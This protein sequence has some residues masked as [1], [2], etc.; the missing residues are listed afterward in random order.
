[1]AGKNIA[2]NK[3]VH[4]VCDKGSGCGDKPVNHNRP[5]VIC[6]SKNEPGNTCD[7]KSSNLGEHVETVP[8]IRSVHFYCL[9]NDATLRRVCLVT[10]P[11]ASSGH[12]LNGPAEDDHADSA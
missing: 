11:C 5:P 7:L 3:G 8:G 4:V 6:R 12:L 9:L 1:M 10:D 2:C